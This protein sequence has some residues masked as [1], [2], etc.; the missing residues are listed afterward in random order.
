MTLSLTLGCNTDYLTLTSEL[1]SPRNPQ[2]ATATAAQ[3]LTIPGKPERDLRRDLAGWHAILATTRPSGLV[4]FNLLLFR[5]SLFHF[6]LQLDLNISVTKVGQ[7]QNRSAWIRA[8][9]ATHFTHTFH[10]LRLGL[11]LGVGLGLRLGVGVGLGLRPK[12]L[13]VRGFDPLGVSDSGVLCACGSNR[14]N[15]TLTPLLI[16]PCPPS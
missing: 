11:G 12:H 16:L 7:S 4:W 5:C 9:T 1:T 14:T 6:L 2:L 15:L 13:R 10:N 8:W 3:L